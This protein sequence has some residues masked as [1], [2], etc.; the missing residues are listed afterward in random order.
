MGLHGLCDPQRGHPSSLSC[1]R[2]M[3]GHEIAPAADKRRVI[4]SVS[5]VPYSPVGHIQS[6][7]K[8]GS[9]AG[10]ER[11]SLLQRLHTFDLKAVWVNG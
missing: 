7:R 10:G 3:D 1:V 5:W 6:W 4:L 2:W 9:G 8:R 11:A